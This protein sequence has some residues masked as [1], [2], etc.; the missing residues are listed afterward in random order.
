M[1]TEIVR[2]SDLDAPE[3]TVLA[4]EILDE[5]D[6]HPPEKGFLDTIEELFN[7]GSAEP[8]PEAAPSPARVEPVAAQVNAPAPADAGE[9][10]TLRARVSELDQIVQQTKL[11]RHPGFQAKY[12]TPIR[13]QTQLAKQLAGEEFS[14][15]ADAALNGDAKAWQ[16]LS[17]KLGPHNSAKFSAIYGAIANLRTE[18]E[19]QLADW[20]NNLAAVDQL[21]AR[22]QSQADAQARAKANEI[23]NEILYKAGKDDVAFRVTGKDA[24]WDKQV[25]GRIDR[26]RQLVGMDWTAEDKAELA[27]AAVSA[28]VHQA[29]VEHQQ[30]ELEKLRALLGRY[31]KGEFGFEGKEQDDP[32]A[33]LLDVIIPAL[34]RQGVLLEG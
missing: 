9:L 33:S 23:A 5:H 25:A 32:N 13:Q 2:K 34:V 22:E 14:L 24:E 12:D 4:R 1:M 18:R 17:E 31:R 21:A 6:A 28:P 26:V 20:K 10:A 3:L 7:S 19:S 29:M 16:F 8:K 15:E 30:R 11:E 27:T